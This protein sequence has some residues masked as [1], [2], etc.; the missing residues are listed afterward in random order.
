MRKEKRCKEIREEREKEMRG[1]G[2]E[3]REEREASDEFEM[4]DEKRREM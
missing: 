4:R 1:G 2:E 3:E